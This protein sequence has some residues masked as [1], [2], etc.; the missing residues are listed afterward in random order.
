M[1]PSAVKLGSKG[2]E[3]LDGETE[4]CCATI[5]Q[6][7]GRSLMSIGAGSSSSSKVS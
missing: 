6:P 2:I 1:P 3:L 5:V 7:H 4:I